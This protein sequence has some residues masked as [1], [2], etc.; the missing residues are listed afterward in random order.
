MPSKRP[1]S[2]PK[3][4]STEPPPPSQQPIDI[5]D[6]VIDETAVVEVDESLQ[7][8]ANPDDEATERGEQG[9]PKGAW[10]ERDANRRAH[11]PDDL[12]D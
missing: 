4:T 1:I 7:E 10:R 12:K 3:T 5:D 8:L 2:N 9:R 6:A 11:G